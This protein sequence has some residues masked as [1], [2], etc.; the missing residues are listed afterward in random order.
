MNQV[1]V[2]H[3][4]KLAQLRADKLGRMPQKQALDPIRNLSSYNLTDNEH[5]ALVNG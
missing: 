4:S 2:T 1:Q 3:E 5:T